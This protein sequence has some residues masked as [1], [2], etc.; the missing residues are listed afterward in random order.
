MKSS[1]KSGLLHGAG[2]TDAAGFLLLTAMAVSVAACTDHESSGGGAAASSADPVAAAAAP[3]HTSKGPVTGTVAETMDAAGYTYLRLSTQRGDQWA[4]VPEAKVT[5]GETVTIVDPMDMEGFKSRALDRTFDHI[6]FGT[7]ASTGAAAA[8]SGNP[9]AAVM[10]SGSTDAWSGP[11]LA[12][13]SGPNAHTIAEVLAG[14]ASLKDKPVTVRGK[15]TKYNASIL[16]KNWLH[17]QD[18]TVK[19]QGNGDLV[20]TSSSTA[21]MGDIV[22]VEGVV[23]TDKDFGAGYAY[24]VMIEDATLTK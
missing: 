20:V 14:K 8:P 16:G 13:A 15:V 21:S 24:P 1:T 17:L 18:G 2:R 19:A 10:Q 12:K 3:A 22:V 7:L 9:H 6:L 4:A 23:R 5:V 11:P